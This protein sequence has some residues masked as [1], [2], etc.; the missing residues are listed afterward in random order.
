MFVC[1]GA[2][3]AKKVCEAIL[4]D[5][6]FIFGGMDYQS[7]LEMDLDELERWHELAKERAPLVLGFK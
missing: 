6:L 1:S 2:I 5:I 4:A 3:K 7:L